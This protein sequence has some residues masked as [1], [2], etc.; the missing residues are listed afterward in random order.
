MS[1]EISEPIKRK[2]SLVFFFKI[3]YYCQW[4]LSWRMSVNHI[5][6]HADYVCMSV[7]PSNHLVMADKG[8]LFHCILNVPSRSN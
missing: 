4:Q 1:E 7:V 8:Q 6:T 5:M 3:Y 2:C